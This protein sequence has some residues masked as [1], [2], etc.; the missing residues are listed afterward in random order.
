MKT[1]TP[2]IFHYS[3]TFSVQSTC[4]RCFRIP[5]I[6][7][8]YMFAFSKSIHLIKKRLKKIILHVTQPIFFQSICTENKK[9]IMR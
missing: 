1:F 9:A 6:N 2:N 8:H 3:N 5:V 7:N 4:F